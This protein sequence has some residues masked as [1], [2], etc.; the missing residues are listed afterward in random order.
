MNIDCFIRPT[1]RR[2]DGTITLLGPYIL[3]MMSKSV[4]VGSGRPGQFIVLN[5]SGSPKMVIKMYFNFF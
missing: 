3:D 4:T 2:Y 1:Y 5:D